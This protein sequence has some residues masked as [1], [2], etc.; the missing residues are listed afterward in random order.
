MEFPGGRNTS[1]AE[2]RDIAAVCIP[3]CKGRLYNDRFICVYLAGIVCKQ[4]D[5]RVMTFLRL[6]NWPKQ[7]SRDFSAHYA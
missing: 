1:T 4:R 3:A 6:S 5:K 2:K 7:A